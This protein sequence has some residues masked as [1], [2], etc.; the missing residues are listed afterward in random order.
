[1]SR[2]LETALVLVLD[3]AEPFDAVRRDFAAATFACGI[4]FHVTL[5]YPFAPSEEL[6]DAVMAETR[7]VFAAREPIE[8]SLTRIA[9]WPDVVYAV[10]EPDAA[11]RECMQALYQLFPSWAPVRGPPA[12]GVAPARRGRAA[13]NA[14]RGCR[15][16]ASRSRDRA[17][18]GA[19]SAQALQARRG[20]AARG[21]RAERVAPPEAFSVRRPLV[22]GPGALPVER[23]SRF[24]DNEG[25]TLRFGV[26]RR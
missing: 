9:T 8:F 6:T 18:A 23:M 5:L 3:D 10:P 19:T 11:L 4:P 2:P 17:A 15:R 20:N 13:C 22:R 16:S 14:R 24:R 25:Q 21:I 26:R 7:D 12:P 1:V